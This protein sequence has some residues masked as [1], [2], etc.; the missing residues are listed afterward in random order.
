MIYTYVE[1][2]AI[3]FGA[4]NHLFENLDLI[5]ANRRKIM[6]HRKYRNIAIEGLF[7]GGLYMGMYELTLGVMLQ[8][9]ANTEWHTGTRYY[10]NIIGSPLSGRNTASWY[11]AET[12]KIESGTYVNKQGLH[13]WGLG[14]PVNEYVRK[15][16][17][18]YKS[19]L[20][21]FDLVKQ[22]QR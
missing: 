20:T 10:Y 17:C 9:W 1:A 2:P 6:F 18:Y 7:A 4:I 14:K 8:L 3:D 15:H 21:I 16:P 22:L 13:F 12:R 19:N 11:D 5:L